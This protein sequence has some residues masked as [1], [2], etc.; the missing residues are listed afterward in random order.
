MRGRQ[1]DREIKLKREH[2]K[3]LSHLFKCC[4]QNV[5]TEFEPRSAIAFIPVY[6]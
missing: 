2:L 6:C 5:P 3:V 4:Q 1:K